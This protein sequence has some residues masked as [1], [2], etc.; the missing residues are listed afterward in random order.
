ML[1]LH[2]FFD[3]HLVTSL[4]L[5]ES[6]VSEKRDGLVL[7]RNDVSKPLMGNEKGI[8]IERLKWEPLLRNTFL[9]NSPRRKSIETLPLSRPSGSEENENFFDKS[10]QNVSF[11]FVLAVDQDLEQPQSCCV[12][13]LKEGVLTTI[14][15]IVREIDTLT[16]DREASFF[17]IDNLEGKGIIFYDIWLNFHASFH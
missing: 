5:S 2:L 16:L 12:E 11:Q 4:S 1:F 17:N 14:D 7:D 6:D 15:S 3:N 9:E 10:E 13:H 8:A